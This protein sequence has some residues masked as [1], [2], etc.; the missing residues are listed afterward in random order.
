M[1]VGVLYADLSFWC[2]IRKP[3]K[4]CY[5]LVQTA[6]E[7][8]QLSP[9]CDVIK[10]KTDDCQRLGSNVFTFMGFV[11]LS[12]LLLFPKW[13]SHDTEH[14]YRSNLCGRCKGI[15]LLHN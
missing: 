2:V 3:Y 10:N 13:R 9:I 1:R 4:H 5:A 7:A 8:S 12:L 14:R 11:S 15:Y 6:K